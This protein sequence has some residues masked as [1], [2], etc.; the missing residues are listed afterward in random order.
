MVI[1]LCK[2]LEEQSICSLIWSVEITHN[3]KLEYMSVQ[4]REQYNLY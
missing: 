3:N 4:L 2:Y 1:H